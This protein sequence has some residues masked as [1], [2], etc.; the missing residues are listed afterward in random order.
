MEGNYQ[1]RLVHEKSPYLL[2][3]ADNPVDWYPWG[4]EA[5]A[6]AREE[7]KP[8]FL[9]IG[10]STCHW[11][12]VMEHESFEDPQIAQ[13]INDY[14][15]PIKVDREERP[16]IDS[17][18]MAVV[19]AMTGRGG[20]PLTVVLTPDKRP[21]F[22]GTYFPPQAKWGSPGLVDIMQSIHKAWQTQRSELVQSSIT[23]TE[24]L[25]ERMREEKGKAQ[26]SDTIFTAGFEQLDRTYDEIFGGF[27][28]APKFPAGHNLSFLLRYWYRKNEPEALQMV[29]HTLVQMA[30]GGMYDH[31]A[32]GFHRYS[33][34]RQW[35]IP[36]FEK[37]LYD[38]AMLAK[39]YLEA[40]QI[41]HQS[42]YAQIAREVFDYVLR[43]M[44]YSQGGFFLLKMRIVSIRRCPLNPVKRLKKRKGLS[45]YGGMRKL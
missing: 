9:S 8:V 40:Y 16:D 27:G 36:H 25:K 39:T 13:M 12:H 32:G 43:D 42:F 37:M 44:Q 6:R 34:D 19:T 45:I 24:M 1:N 21:F 33:T 26:L 4:E 22:G 2:Q 30:N 23:F 17:I 5:F 15:V 31:V 3:H 35:Q 20:W 11:C 28:H 10:Y 41:T 29:E 14:F 18:Y 38:Q 7:D